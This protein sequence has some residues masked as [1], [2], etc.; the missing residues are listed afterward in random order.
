MKHPT[1]E[2]LLAYLDLESTDA[3]RAEIERHLARCDACVTM[4]ARLRQE[5]QILTSGLNA[6]DLAE[7]GR[8]RADSPWLRESLDRAMSE[9]ARHTA[10]AGGGTEGGE[11]QP[12]LRVVKGG[13][14]PG[15]EREA[16]GRRWSF[17][18]LR[19][20]AG[21]TFIAVAGAS[22]AVVG[23]P[24]LR[25]FDKPEPAQ[26]TVAEAASTPAAAAV[27]VSPANGEIT[28]V[29]T[30]SVPG[31]RL[32]IDPVDA[33]EV[34]VEVRGDGEARFQARDGLVRADLGGVI[35]HVRVELPRGVESSTIM[36]GDRVVARAAFGEVTPAAA[37]GDG[38]VL[39]S[40]D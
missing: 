34:L 20:A 4:L 31:T 2:S 9:A 17:T 12:R 37:T 35:T 30:N 19:W 24:G 23:I 1:E 18:A 28:V 16:P 11:Q 29:L 10:H 14:A 3:E 32:V 6:L 8:W 26:P 39:E 36:V 21:I 40:G 27:A 13:A 22:A 7:P 25:L 5:S 15:H 38:L 33:G